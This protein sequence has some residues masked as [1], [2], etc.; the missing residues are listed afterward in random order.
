MY[1]LRALAM[2]TAGQDLIQRNAKGPNI[3]LKGEFVFLQAL[4]GIPM[5]T[6]KNTVEWLSWN[7][8]LNPY[9][10]CCV[11]LP[12]DGTVPLLTDTIVDIAFRDVFGQAKVSNLHQT[13]IF[14]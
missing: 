9:F 8:S 13:L 11:N 12:E 2:Y 1:L 10:K 4:K 5:H 7:R 3:W 6:E 14:H